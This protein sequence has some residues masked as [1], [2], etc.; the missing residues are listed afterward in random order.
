ML[1]N[2]GSMYDSPSEFVS[3]QS[4]TRRLECTTL[5]S[6]NLAGV[7]LP[8]HLERL[9]LERRALLS[10]VNPL[11]SLLEGEQPTFISDIQ[12]DMMTEQAVHMNAYLDVLSL[13]I[14]NLI[15]EL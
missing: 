5:H 8:P 2:L 4:Q 13:R 14:T 1:D 15:E 12:W 10:K 6:S 9:I 3:I 11:T 7:Q